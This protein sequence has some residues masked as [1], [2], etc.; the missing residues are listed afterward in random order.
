M[1]GRRQLIDPD[2]GDVIVADLELADTFWRRFRG[3][4]FRKP[5]EADQGLLLTPCRSIHTHWMWFS[6]D[7]AMLDEE[8]AV[9][10]VLS[11][12]PPW[13]IVKRVK[14]THSVLETA[15]GRLSGLRVGSRTQVI[16]P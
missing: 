2:S 8:G 1:A 13:R 3:L 12:V 14:G 15:A 9:L 6:I 5:L 11:S 10:A 4:Q 7:A 16:S